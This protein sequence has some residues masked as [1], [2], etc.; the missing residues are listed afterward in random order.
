MNPVDANILIAP[1]G[2]ARIADFGVAKLIGSQATHTD[3]SIDLI[4][5][6]SNVQFYIVANGHVNANT[7][8]YTSQ[9]TISPITA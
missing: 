5:S 1:D 7:E 4:P 9:A 2:R 6:A 8:G 3:V